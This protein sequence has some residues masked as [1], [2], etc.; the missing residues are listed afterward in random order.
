MS[1]ISLSGIITLV[2]ENSE[3]ILQDRS[4]PQNARIRAADDSLHP[5]SPPYP[6]GA[7]ITGA[8]EPSL[9]LKLSYDMLRGSKILSHS[10]V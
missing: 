2:K 9:G 6:L 4:V 1:Q 5:A 7:A 10:W 8:Y 3:Y